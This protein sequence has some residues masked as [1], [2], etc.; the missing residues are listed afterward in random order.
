MHPMRS[1]HAAI[2]SAAVVALLAFLFFIPTSQAHSPF[3]NSVRIIATD[4]GLD[5]SVVLGADAAQAFLNRAGAGEHRLPG[6]VGVL[7]LPAAAADGLCRLWADESVLTPSPIRVR[8][9]GLEYAFTTSYPRPA[10]EALSF[11]ARYFQ[12]IPGIANGTLLVT[13]ENGVQLD[14]GLLSPSS[15]IVGLV[16]PRVRGSENPV[17]L[18]ADSAPAI[19]AAPAS[20]VS[21]TSPRRHASFASFL[22]LGITHILTGYDHL[23][24]LFALLVAC[25]RLGPMLAIVTC[26][27]AAHSVT[28]ALAALDV[29][30][31]SPRLVEPLIA[32]SIVFVGLE[33]V[34]GH[35]D[36][37]T[38]CAVTLGFGLVHGFG[39]AGALRETGL[40]GKGAEI[41]APLLAFNLGVECGQ[42]AVA[43]VFLPLLFLARRAASFERYGTAAA[44]ALV[45]AL[46]GFWLVQRLVL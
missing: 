46:G 35:V 7:E 37:K 29:V 31:L 24:F 13:D 26:F 41:I 45:V 28:L 2:R 12:S 4:S 27:T 18:A 5:V 43:A 10:G 1:N 23:L 36:W 16:L 34:R 25:K 14:S 15:T 33:N 32:A 30:H 20:D 39:F 8:G 22:R 3:D 40:A 38:R 11:E 21:A 42:L 44:S 17:T 9:D 19:D 6:P